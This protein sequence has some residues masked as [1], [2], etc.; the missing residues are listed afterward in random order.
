MMKPPVKTVLR[1]KIWVLVVLILSL[2]TCPVYGEALPQKSIPD[3]YID[4]AGN[5]ILLSLNF[6]DGIEEGA[7]VELALAESSGIA[8]NVKIESRPDLSNDAERVFA[9]TFDIAG[10]IKEGALEKLVFVPVTD[11]FLNYDANALQFQFRAVKARDEE[12]EDGFQNAVY[13]LVRA[14]TEQT[15]SLSEGYATDFNKYDIGGTYTY[16][17]KEELEY[18]VQ[19]GLT[20]IPLKIVLGEPFEFRGKIIVNSSFSEDHHCHSSKIGSLD[21]RAQKTCAT[22]GEE[23][24]FGEISKSGRIGL[25]S[26]GETDFIIRYTPIECEVHGFGED[27]LTSE[28]FSC[29][30]PE[31]KTFFEPERK[32]DRNLINYK[33]QITS[34]LEGFTPQVTYYT[35]NTP[36]FRSGVKNGFVVPDQ[37]MKEPE[38]TQFKSNLENPESDEAIIFQLWDQKLKISLHY[39]PVLNGGSYISSVPLF[40]FSREKTT[41]LPGSEGQAGSQDESRSITPELTGHSAQ[42]AA[43]IAKKA[44]LIPE[45]E[46]GEET[47]DPKQEGVVYKQIPPPSTPLQPGSHITMLVHT[48]AASSAVPDLTGQPAQEAAAIAVRAGL[49]PEFEVGEETR[50]PKKEGVVYKQIP[51]PSTQLQPGSRIT[52]LVHTVAALPAVP[53]VIGS[54]PVVASEALARAGLTAVFEVGEE[55]RDRKK[56]NIVYH[57]NPSSG[58]TVEA[59]SNVVMKLYSF[60]EVV[61]P[62]KVTIPP[63]ET[64]SEYC[65]LGKSGFIYQPDHDYFVFRSREPRKITS[66]VYSR[67]YRFVPDYA[68]AGAQQIQQEG[69]MDLI[70]KGRIPDLCPHL[71]E[72]CS[73]STMNNADKSFF[74]DI[75]GAWE[76][77]AP[78]PV[79]QRPAKLPDLRGMTVANAQKT[80]QGIDM[81]I[82]VEL[83]EA[84]AK[85]NNVNIVYK[86]SP[87]PGIDA[88]KGGNVTVWIYGEYIS[89][90]PPNPVVKGTPLI[91][92]PTAIA[93]VR[94]LERGLSI[95]SVFDRKTR[96]SY[97]EGRIE[98]PDSIMKYSSYHGGR[99]VTNTYKGKLV[100]YSGGGEGSDHMVLQAVWLAEGDDPS[101]FEKKIPKPVYSK[102]YES[103]GG[104]VKYYI[105]RGNRRGYI[106]ILSSRSYAYVYADCLPT[107]AN[108]N[109]LEQYSEELAKAARRLFDQIEKYAKP[110]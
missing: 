90:P 60:A 89:V 107:K 35:V 13:H 37:D 58:S 84:A 40:R 81:K 104:R 31:G 29:Q 96:N 26:T 45:F 8:S 100:R 9:V 16:K 99:A 66:S 67:E 6:E 27:H 59:G 83:G 12:K 70:L 17:Y 30:S 65:S 10:D 92:M 55:T 68:E 95:Y 106:L 24:L 38:R 102:T 75:C 36:L 74:R 77:P 3:A 91:T 85:Q 54:D 72:R 5:E 82:S 25:N 87:G 2:M 97:P 80:L 43:A 69:K 98:Q 15:R 20:D 7:K 56:E 109:R 18:R 52:M 41:E 34:K 101:Q 62:V 71:R 1:T 14:G 110:R 42:E 79:S 22:H 4:S 103:T 88:A 61:Q 94:Q 28:H 21:E 32:N 23:F 47:R 76:D 39:S 50:D 49:I 73:L 105:D 63:E 33:Y 46:V 44:G 48:V 19:A 11:Q 51:S 57:Q 78:A 93:G 86:Q 64:A 108:E 53:D